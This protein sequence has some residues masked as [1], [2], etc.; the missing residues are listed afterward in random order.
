MLKLILNN[1]YLDKSKDIRNVFLGNKV[2]RN[3]ILSFSY[4]FIENITIFN[5]LVID[6]YIT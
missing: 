1:E 5:F 6:L 4:T 3:F 2:E